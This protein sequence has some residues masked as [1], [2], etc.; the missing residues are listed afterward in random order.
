MKP[1]RPPIKDEFSELPISKQQKYQLRKVSR[2][3]CR[4]CTEP[5]AGAVYCKKHM[6]IN[7]LRQVKP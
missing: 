6:E 2:G 5:L 1:G 3:V 7:R 4:V